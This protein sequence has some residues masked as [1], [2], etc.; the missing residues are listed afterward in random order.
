MIDYFTIYKV[1]LALIYELDLVN[2]AIA[3]VI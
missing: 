3:A 2:Y 1:A